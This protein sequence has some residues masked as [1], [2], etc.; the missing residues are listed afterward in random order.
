[1][2]V[3]GGTTKDYDIA[4]KTAECY[5]PDSNSWSSV[6]DMNVARVSHCLVAANGMLFAIGG[7]EDGDYGLDIMDETVIDSMEVYNPD[8]DTWTMIEEKLDGR[9]AYSGACALVKWDVQSI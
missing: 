3:T 1:M 5:D 8:T 6:A 7:F 9:V 2:Y 4:L